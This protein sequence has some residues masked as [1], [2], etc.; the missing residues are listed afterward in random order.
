MSTLWEGCSIHLSY[1]DRHSQDSYQGI[2]RFGYNQ[3]FKR[4]LG[5]SNIKVMLNTDYREV[6]TVNHHSKQIKFMGQVFEGKLIFTGKID[7]LFDYCY[8]ELPLS[9]C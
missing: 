1:D 2:P 7:E 3:L 9:N 8:G 5:N 6:V 4:M